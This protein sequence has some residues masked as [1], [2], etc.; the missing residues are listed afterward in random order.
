M[1]WNRTEHKDEVV[2]RARTARAQAQASSAVAH[3]LHSHSRR[4][5]Q[6]AAV[7]MAGARIVEQ[8]AETAL[9]GRPRGVGLVIAGPARRRDELHGALSSRLASVLVATDSVPGLGLAI[10]EQPELVLIDD[11][12]LTMNGLDTSYLIRAYVPDT[13]VILLTRDRG[14]IEVA[15]LNGIVVKTPAISRRQLFT[16]IDA[17]LVA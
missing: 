12:L 13:T 11:H 15:R 14:S 10:S 2:R 5:Q 1:F 8:P 7:G 9:F 3:V 16:T 6:E 4:L 17:A